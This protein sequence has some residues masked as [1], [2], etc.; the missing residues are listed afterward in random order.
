[1]SNEWNLTKNENTISREKEGMEK[2]ME[3]GRKERKKERKS[4]ILNK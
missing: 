2:G 1:M 4:K 3:K